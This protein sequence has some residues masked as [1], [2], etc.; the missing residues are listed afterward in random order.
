MVTQNKEKQE[1][2]SE[3]IKQRLSFSEMLIPIIALVMFVI[4]I[5]F[6]YIPQVKAASV[7]KNKIAI[8]KDEEARLNTNISQV[9]KLNEDSNLVMQNLN[10]AQIV[11][12]DEL[13]VSDFSFKI[14]D[15]ALE[16]GLTL[17][18]LSSSDVAYAN[19]NDL[20]FVT[21]VVKGITGP[22]RYEGSFEDIVDFLEHIKLESPYLIDTSE[23][24]LRKFP[25][26]LDKWSLDLALTGYYMV[27]SDDI[28]SDPLLPI[29]LYTSLDVELQD[30][31]ARSGIINQ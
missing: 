17:Q 28:N 21:G 6:V 3:D 2:Q 10:I 5:I 12:S 25:E 18:S 31:L 14:T 26:E 22:M 20:I 29:K 9:E 16:M 15:L 4:L 19:N 23:I 7:Y 30:L 11:I 24:R 13:A 1:E 8:L 27:D